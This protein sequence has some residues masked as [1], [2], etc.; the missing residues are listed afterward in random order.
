MEDG[1]YAKKYAVKQVQKEVPPEYQ[2]VGRF[3]AISRNLK[4]EPTHYGPEE[5]ANL[6][7]KA[8]VPWEPASIRHYFDK[9][10]RRY[11]EKLMNYDRSGQRRTDKKTGK[12]LRYK[13]ASMTRACSE[14]SGN[15]KIKNGAR[16][17]NQLLNYIV[18]NP[19]D[20]YSLARAIAERVPF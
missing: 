9:I 7:R 14:L 18:S 1:Q 19:P 10:L 4:P 20:R 12:A 15:F 5:V 6:T 16:I 2:N 13:K 3:W 17:I 11:Q 8:A